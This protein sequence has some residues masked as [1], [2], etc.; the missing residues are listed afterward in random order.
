MISN[1]FNPL[2]EGSN[3]SVGVQFLMEH[4]QSGLLQL[5]TKQSVVVRRLKGSNPL[6]SD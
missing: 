3:P 6:C 2:V 1:T 4:W 5:P